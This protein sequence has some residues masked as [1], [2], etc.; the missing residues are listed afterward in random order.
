MTAA[1]AIA[2]VAVADDDAALVGRLQSGDETAFVELVRRYQPRL[3]RLAES[4]VGRGAVAQEVT[5][6]TWLAVFRGVDR[7]EGRSSFKTW[8]F[9]ILLNRARSAARREERAGRV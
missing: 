9:R 4:T 6:D 2:S 5:Q 3:L 1:L 8:L 7:F